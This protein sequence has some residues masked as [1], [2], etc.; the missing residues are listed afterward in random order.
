VLHVRQGQRVEV[1]FRNAGII[2]HSFD[3]HAARIAS[4]V[5][6]KDIGVGRSLRFSFVARDPGVFLYHCVTGPA[7]MHIANGMF[8]AIVVDPKQPL[9][10]AQSEYVLVASEWYLDRSGQRA[11]A[12]LDLEKALAMNPDWVT[13]N[14]RANQYVGRPLHVRP[15]DRVRFYVVN[16]G[17]NLV[18][19]FHLVG[20]VFDRVYPDGDITHP[21]TGVQTADVAPGGSTIF[22]A[23]F[24][25]PGLYGFVSHMFANA[26]KGENGDILVGNA[27]GTMTH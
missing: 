2:P 12:D 18:T 24:D 26:E 21:L 9:P 10:R 5:A 14:G 19:P 6:F 7:V 8:G 3:I 20:G 17:P 27:K 22:D 15:H 1:T 11:P 23:H 4:N 13:F 25:E 16:A